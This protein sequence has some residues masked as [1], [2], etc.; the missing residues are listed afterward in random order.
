MPRQSLIQALARVECQSAPARPPGALEAAAARVALVLAAELCEV[1][2]SFVSLVDENRVWYKSSHGKQSVQAPRDDSYCSWA[3]LEK[4]E[5]VIPDVR[6][7]ARLLKLH[8]RLALQ[9]ELVAFVFEDACCGLRVVR[10][11]T[12]SGCGVCRR[13]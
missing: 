6:E 11:E 3:I 8:D 9:V 10:F 4:T 12:T 7:D 2:Y 13:C 5:L 1:P